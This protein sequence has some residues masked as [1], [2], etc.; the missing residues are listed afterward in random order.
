[1]QEAIE[2][3][4]RALSEYVI[5]GVHTTIPFHQKLLNHPVFIKGE[6][7]TGFL[8]TYGDIMEE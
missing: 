2:R 5:E 7:T 3:M 1:R 4:K 8:E 6:V